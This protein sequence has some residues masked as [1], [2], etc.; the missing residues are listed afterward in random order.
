M[1]GKSARLIALHVET[2][3]TRAAL[4][5]GVSQ[6]RLAELDPRDVFVRLWERDHIEPPSE[7]VLAAFDRLV[8]ELRGDDGDL[9][10]S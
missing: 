2:T 9:G 1:E 8:A 7:A 5:D 3:G 6:R 4:A 10:A